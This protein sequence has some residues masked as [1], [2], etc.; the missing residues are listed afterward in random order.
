MMEVK[1]DAIG[2][3]FDLD[4]I[5]AYAARNGMQN[6]FAHLE[7][8]NKILT[9]L[10][11]YALFYPERYAE[12]HNLNEGLGEYNEIFENI[13]NGI[14]NTMISLVPF[15]EAD[16]IY[17]GRSATGWCLF[18]RFIA[19]N[20]SSEHI[21]SFRREM[22]TC[23]TLS[24]LCRCDLY[25]ANLEEKRA[26]YGS[27]RYLHC[28]IVLDLTGAGLQTVGLDAG[29]F[30][31][32]EHSGFATLTGWIKPTNGFLV[33]DR[34]GN[35]LIESG[36]ELFGDNTLLKD[37]VTLANNG[38]HALAEFD[39]NGDGVID[40]NDPIYHELRVWVD[41]NMNGVADP[42]ELYTLPELGIKSINLNYM[43]PRTGN[44]LTRTSFYTTFD[45]EIR[46]VGEFLFINDPFHSLE[47]DYTPRT[48][49]VRAL[50][51]IP[52]SG[53]LVSLHTAMV[54]DPILQG[55]VENYA[56]EPSYA[57]RRAMVRPII[58]RW[59]EVENI[60]PRS[61][62]WS[63]DAR[64]LVVLETIF[65]QGF[66]GL[67][68]TSNP[69][70][71]V[72]AALS[73]LFER[74]MNYVFLELEAQ[75]W[76]KELLELDTNS[77][78]DRLENILDEDF[79]F[80]TGLLRSLNTYLWA[81]NRKDHVQLKLH[82]LHI[83]PMAF[84]EN[85][86][87]GTDGN[88]ELTV[89]N[90]RGHFVYGMGG[91]DII[92]VTGG[93]DNAIDPGI[94]NNRIY[95]GSG[96]DMYFIGRNYGIN[97]ITANSNNNLI[98]RD[99][100][101]FKDDISPDEIFI[102]RVGNNLEINVLP[103]ELISDRAIDCLSVLD[104]VSNKVILVNFFVLN[105]HRIVDIRFPDG[106]VWV[107]NDDLIRSFMLNLT[108]ANGLNDISENLLINYR[109]MADI[110]LSGMNWMPIGTQAAPFLGTFDGN[111][112]TINNLNINQPTMDNMGL[113]GVNNGSIRNLHLENA[114]IIG[115]NN[116]G[117]VAGR[118]MQ[119]ITNVTVDIA[120]LTGVRGVGG[121]VGINDN[122]GIITESSVTGTGNV[123]G[124]NDVGGLA[125][126]NSGTI[127]LSFATV[128][129]SGSSSL[130]GGLIGSMPT[131]LV[132]QS[133]ATGNVSALGNFGG[134]I[135]SFT[136]NF[137]VIRNS[138]STGNTASHPSSAGFIG[139]TSGTP[140][141]ENSYALSNNPEGFVRG[142]ARV[143]N[144]FFELDRIGVPV[145]S[146][147]GRTRAQMQQQAT[148]VGWDF[149]SIWIMEDG[150]YPVLRGVGVPFMPLQFAMEPLEMLL[151]DLGTNVALDKSVY[152]DVGVWR[153]AHYALDG[154][155]YT[156]F[157][158]EYRIGSFPRA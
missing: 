143:T 112:H 105:R 132:E 40:E 100:L 51:N 3:G 107:M 153:D 29:V 66:I 48:P 79:E 148:F 152:I 15:W 114:R 42:G 85:L 34:T 57:A 115:R 21:G 71:L 147:H 2:F 117:S 141:I 41:K 19:S 55:M 5:A 32:M 123:A 27:S 110:D 129:V 46:E 103:R 17:I 20:F 16:W 74:Y 62:G 35:G 124:S 49:E 127:R 102:I 81:I 88:D 111:G 26:E 30:F 125:G 4:S 130:V 144:S 113:F 95:G 69:L 139:H 157:E 158:S 45:G 96:T 83:S 101:I 82:F 9:P 119:S 156:Y 142:N 137:S 63:V 73:D 1:F 52:V 98:T 14:N 39:L 118:N 61:R 106:T 65:A 70:P 97:T 8:I 7:R 138:F 84:Y 11:V 68:G 58:F 10:E 13:L 22:G 31:D 146:P 23:L 140:L 12:I 150:S 145:N 94:G 99:R 121:L 126:A 47:R 109:L 93:G 38:F 33:L 136:G 43:V 89:P 135:G 108:A 28:P 149:D 122:S 131:G 134:F 60:E 151:R 116:T 128:N 91:N 104:N 92:R 6:S 75:S 77:L 67:D 53:R 120:E 76:L 87:I 64:E 154:S 25:H 80:G 90:N 133:Y 24:H 54:R 36:R 72:G 18:A 155:P 44:I 86:L 56:S 37:G 59:A 78:L 50:P